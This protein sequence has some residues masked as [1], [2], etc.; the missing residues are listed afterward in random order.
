MK[1][2]DRGS[3]SI[4]FFLIACDYVM[5]ILLTDPLPSI[6][7]VSGGERPGSKPE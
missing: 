7:I 1:D 2:I 5:D 6:G 4:C 3:L